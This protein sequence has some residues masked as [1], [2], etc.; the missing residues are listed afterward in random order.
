M[1]NL[2]DLIKSSVSYDPKS[3]DKFIEELREE[4]MFKGYNINSSNANLFNVSRESFK[5]CKNCKG[6]EEC[7]NTVKGF[8]K[9]YDPESDTLIAK[10]CK[11][12]R[13][14]AKRE[15]D[16]RLFKTLFM[17]DNILN[18]TLDEYSTNTEARKKALAMATKFITSF[19]EETKG[20]YLNGFFGV[21]K[22]YLLAAT[23]NELSKRGINVILAYF[24]DLVR[25]IKNNMTNGT[26]LE[27]ILNTLKTVDVLMLDDF[28]S[29]NLSSWLRDDIL[30]PI[31]NYRYEAKKPICISSN[32]NSNQLLEHLSQTN[33]GKD[34]LKGMRLMKRIMSLTNE[35]TLGSDSEF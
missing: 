29:E 9:V 17:P 2:K 22:T 34:D 28:G 5:H 6:L 16:S 21:G 30:G 23:A 15:Y 7:P 18:Y 35:L 8:N 19:K 33:D 14:L 13:I 31:I 12:K 25:E 11:F 20:I 24:P 10:E 26:K 4:P 1:N 3:V 32:L 27:E